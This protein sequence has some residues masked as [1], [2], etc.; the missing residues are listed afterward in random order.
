MNYTQRQMMK[1]ASTAA[2]AEITA[3][4]RTY[5]N[6]NLPECRQSGR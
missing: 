4:V 6:C 5:E 3:W 1:P 2:Q